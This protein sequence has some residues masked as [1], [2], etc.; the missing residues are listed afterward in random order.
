MNRETAR[1]WHQKD[2]AGRDEYLADMKAGGESILRSLQ[3]DH[4]FKHT[5]LIDPDRLCQR[6]S[7]GQQSAEMIDE[8]IGIEGLD[9]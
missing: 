2:P 5:C 7:L 6:C 9:F 4:D 8:G 3:E 1:K